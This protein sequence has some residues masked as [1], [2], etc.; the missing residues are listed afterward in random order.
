MQPATQSGPRR[1]GARST[2][3]LILALAV[4]WLVFSGKYDAVHLAYGV[5]SVFLVLLLTRDLVVA[6]RDP[7]ENEA[8]ARLNWPKLIVYPVWL[9]TQIIIANVQVSWIIIRPSMPIDPVLIT[10]RTGMKSSLAKVTLGNS[11]I[12]T[13]GTFT[14]RIVEDEFLVHSIHE[15]LAGSLLDGSMQRKVAA[16]FGET[17]VEDLQV[18]VL[19]DRTAVEQEV[20]R[21][22]S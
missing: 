15:G 9:V 19:R 13:P 17:V 10:F 5:L 7:A 12:L 1:R 18:R 14:L 22:T 20:A 2:V 3:L 21:W 8:I 6:R 11:I 4:L 16:L